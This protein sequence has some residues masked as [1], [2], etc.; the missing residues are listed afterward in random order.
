MRRDIP[1][2]HHHY[3]RSWHSKTL[4]REHIPMVRTP[5]QDHQRLRSAFHLPLRKSHHPSAG[6]HAKPVNSI[7]PPNQ[8]PIR[9]EEP[10]GRTISPINLY[11][12]RRLGPLATNGN[13]ST[14][15]RL[16]CHHR[17]LPEHATLRMGTTALSG[18]EHTHFE[19]ES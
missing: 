7:P 6:N 5:P 14:Q 19:S 1:S 11:Q 13:G 17:I 12:S 8:R 15:Q 18:S 10:M 9:T 2:L 4:P 3:H 16:E